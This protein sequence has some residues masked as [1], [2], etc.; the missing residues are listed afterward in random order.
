MIARKIKCGMT[1]NKTPVM[2]QDIEVGCY[3]SIYPFMPD[4]IVEGGKS[5]LQALW[6]K[7]VVHLLE[8]PVIP[9]LIGPNGYEPTLQVL[10]LDG[11][12]YTHLFHPYLI[13]FVKG[14]NSN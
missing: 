10:H 3:Y 8:A 9:V 2:C 4:L 13:D 14:M 6:L 7:G 5:R 11:P 12:F 1:D